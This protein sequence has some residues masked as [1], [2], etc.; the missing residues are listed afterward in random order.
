M[1]KLIAAVLAMSMMFTMG[2]NAFARKPKENTENL[3]LE[4]ET[5][6]IVG[7]DGNTYTLTIQDIT[8]AGANSRDSS[9]GEEGGVLPGTIRV[10]TVRATNEQLD[11]VGAVDSAVAYAIKLNIANKLVAILNTEFALAVG[12]AAAVAALAGN[13]NA[14]YGYTGFEATIE[15]EWQH[16]VNHAEGIDEYAWGFVDLIHFGSY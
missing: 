9:S 11:V 12:F 14:R 13:I 15:M 8:P 2:V 5:I 16:F 10:V 4:S 7:D 1:K 3:F 6:Q